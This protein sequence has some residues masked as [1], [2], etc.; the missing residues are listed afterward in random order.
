VVAELEEIIVPPDALELEQL[1][2]DARY[3]L[4][5]HPE[6]AS[7]GRLAI[8]AWSGAGS[9]LRSSLPLAVS[10]SAASVTY[11][12]GIM[13]SGS[14]ASQLAAQLRRRELG[15]RLP[16]H[17]GHQ[18]LIVGTVLAREHHRLAP[19]TNRAGGISMALR[20]RLPSPS[21]MTLPR[22]PAVCRRES[23]K[24]MFAIASRIV[25]P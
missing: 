23:Q 8:E 6:G 10:G 11:A 2:P 13:Y 16:G 17:I 14:T 9:A 21:S 12:A 4:F 22:L 25:V 18:A 5:H 7:Y 20:T 15:P 1:L 24:P 19:I 3:T